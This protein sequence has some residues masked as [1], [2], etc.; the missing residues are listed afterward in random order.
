MEQAYKIA[1]KFA[2]SLPASKERAKAYE[3]AA[4]A[5]NAGTQGIAFAVA[6]DHRTDDAMFRAMQFAE[7]V[8]IAKDQ[9]TTE[10]PKF[11]FLDGSV[12]ERDGC[13]PAGSCA[14]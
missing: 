7:Y 8:G 3:I 4:C 2:Q 14:Q 11:V 12:W 5:K 9:G 1:F 6:N 10:S 13:S